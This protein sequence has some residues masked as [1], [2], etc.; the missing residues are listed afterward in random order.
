MAVQVEPGSGDRTIEGSK[1]V[2]L[3]APPAA[4]IP[5]AA[6]I[7]AAAETPGPAAAS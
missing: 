6:D 3:A 2:E 7:V 4:V 5:T 1:A